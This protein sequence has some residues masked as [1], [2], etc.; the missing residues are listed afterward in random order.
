MKLL[1]LKDKVWK[2]WK[3]FNDASGVITQEV[4]FVQDVKRFGDRR[5]KA[6]WIRALAQFT[7]QA[8]YESCLDAYMLVLDNFNFTTNRWD[9]EY[10]HEILDA[11]LAYPDA[12]D[13]IRT[14]L[15]QLFS[16][17]F[18]PREREEA[19]GFFEL[20]E[21]RSQQPGRDGLPIRLDWR[22]P[23]TSSAA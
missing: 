1:E 5:Y 19:D 4:T 2:A 20:V 12:L 17:E 13:L 15:E 11:F 10:R 23:S 8:S 7:A 14:G 22:L 16:S 9:Y 3:L 18:A 6:T 21:E